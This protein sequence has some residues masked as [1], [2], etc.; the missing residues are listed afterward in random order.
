MQDTV[1][2]APGEGV[3]YVIQGESYTCGM[4]TLGFNSAEEERTNTEPG[5]CGGAGVTDAYPQSEG[6][7]LGSVTGTHSNTSASDDQ[8][9]SITEVLSSGGSPANR[10]SQLE[11]HWTTQVTAGSQIELHVEGFR[12]SSPDGDDF[13]FEYSTNGGSSWTATGLPSLP[14]ADPDADLS[15]ALPA[16]LSGTVMLRVIDTNRTQGTQ[17]LDTVSIDELFIR[18]IP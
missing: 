6:A 2:L 4:G 16:S 10:F 8:L 17:D 14:T 7:V 15:A 9:Q 13:A 1:A 3:F 18:S 5:A 12:T 11:H